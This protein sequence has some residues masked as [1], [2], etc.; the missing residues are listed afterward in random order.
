[1]IIKKERNTIQIPLDKSMEFKLL[2]QVIAKNRRKEPNFLPMGRETLNIRKIKILIIFVF[3]Q[4]S[5]IAHET[6]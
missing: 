2:N 6:G 4:I 1:M 3:A 5:T